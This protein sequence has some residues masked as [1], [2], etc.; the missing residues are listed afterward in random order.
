MGILRKYEYFVRIEISCIFFHVQTVYDHVHVCVLF[1]YFWIFFLKL[2]K[3]NFNHSY[4][5]LQ[6]KIGFKNNFFSSLL[7]YFKKSQIFVLLVSYC[8]DLNVLKWFQNVLELSCMY[9]YMPF[10]LQKIVCVQCNGIIRWLLIEWPPWHVYIYTMT[11]IQLFYLYR[12]YRFTNRFQNQR[13]SPLIKILKKRHLS[14]LSMMNKLLSI[15]NKSW[16]SSGITLIYTPLR[17]SS[18]D[19]IT[20]DSMNEPWQVKII[21]HF[22]F[23]KRNQNQ[24]SSTELSLGR[25]RIFQS[26]G[27][28]LW[29]EPDFFFLSRASLLV[30]LV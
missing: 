24:T 14:P 19:M 3:R 7:Y 1:S 21:F 18:P 10:P 27:Q 25:K 15:I 11:V 13:K 12:K 22:L 8:N 23:A 9:I 6:I 30:L 4:L 5:I 20:T 29:F 28:L 17:N 16:P 26:G 2:I